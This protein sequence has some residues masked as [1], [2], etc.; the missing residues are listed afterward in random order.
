FVLGFAVV[1]HTLSLSFLLK[2]SNNLF[3]A[4]P[5]FFCACYFLIQNKTVITAAVDEQLKEQAFTNIDGAVI[6]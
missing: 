5:H 6:V 1:F 3:T 2:F 4:Y